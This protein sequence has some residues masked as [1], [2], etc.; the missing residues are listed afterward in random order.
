MNIALLVAT[1]LQTAGLGSLGVS[2]F[3]GRI[4]SENTA[5]G[6]WSVKTMPGGVNEG[7]NVAKWRLR[8]PLQ[9]TFHHSDAS[10]LYAKDDIVR[11]ALSNIPY[12]D[13]RFIEVNVSPMQD[14]DTAEGE[15]RIGVWSVET[16]T[17]NA[18]EEAEQE[19]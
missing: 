4:P 8:T 5:N 11:A 17:F 18:L 13:A 2:I 6:L 15:R 14:D 19:S 3:V 9:V 7:G 10:A 12:S 1:A 16:V